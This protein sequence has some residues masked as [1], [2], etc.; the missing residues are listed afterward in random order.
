MSARPDDA[1]R[2]GRNFFRSGELDQRSFWRNA[3]RW[4]LFRFFSGFFRWSGSGFGLVRADFFPEG[5]YPYRACQVL[6]YVL[7]QRR[8]IF[9]GH[10]RSEKSQGAEYYENGEDADG[11][12]NIQKQR[13]AAPVAPRFI[14]YACCWHILFIYNSFDIMSR[15]KTGRYFKFWFFLGWAFA[16]LAVFVFFWKFQAIPAEVWEVGEGLIS[17]TKRALISFPGPDAVFRAP[18]IIIPRIGVDAEL[19]FP[20]SADFNVLNAALS[21]GP[22]HFPGSALPGEEGNVFIFAHASELPVVKNP[23]YKVFSG[24]RK[25]TPGDIV[26]IQSGALVYRYR[27]LSLTRRKADDAKIDLGSRKKMLTLSTCDV[28]GGK[29]FRWVVEAEFAGSYSLAPN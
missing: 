20:E 11:R 19:I 16:V 18:A 2:I 26:K 27:V 24:L 10:A 6:G 3:G 1:A 12:Q 23:A 13:V 15:M 29:E 8:E 25:L 5:K 14:A 4:G 22:V 17:M 7:G 9:N 21:R 28:F